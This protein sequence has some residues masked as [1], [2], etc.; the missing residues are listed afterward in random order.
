MIVEAEGR[1]FRGADVYVA[2]RELWWA[3]KGSAL[4]SD[5]RLDF[6]FNLM[7]AMA[8]DAVNSAAG[9]EPAATGE[10]VA[11]LMLR[12]ETERLN[13]PAHLLAL[14]GLL[15]RYLLSD[16]SARDTRELDAAREQ[17]RQAWWSS[18]L[19]RGLLASGG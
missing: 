8:T 5:E 14:G 2:F 16:E 6:I 1:R 15:G 10:A 18:G 13:T 11:A 4:Y 12:V 19:D 7:R 9:A 17:L 3:A